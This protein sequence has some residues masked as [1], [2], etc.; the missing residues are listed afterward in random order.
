[1]GVLRAFVFEEAFD[2]EAIPVTTA[3]RALDL[4]LGPVL[5]RLALEAGWRYDPPVAERVRAADLTA[6]AVTADKYAVVREVLEAADGIGCRVVLLKGIATALR[7][8]PAPHL[9]GMDDIDV[10][11]EPSRQASLEAAIRARGFEQHSAAPAIAFA[12]LHHSMPFRRG[13]EGAWVELHGRLSPPGAAH[14]QDPQFSW[15]QVS[16]HLA[17]VTVSD[18]PALVMNHELQLVYTCARWAEE[19]APR[20]VFPLLDVALLLRAHGD[21]LDWNRVFLI[22]RGSWTGAAVRLVLSYLR[23][24][25]LAAIPARV[26]DELATL[27]RHLNDMS[28][29][30]LHRLTTRYVIDG[31]PFGQAL[32][33][34]G[35]LQMVWASVL[36]TRSP[37]ANLLSVPYHLAFPPGRPDRFHPRLAL[38]RLRRLLTR[39][40]HGRRDRQP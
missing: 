25:G 35:Q 33:T 3:A 36:G 31:R 13:A 38:E 1:L 24:I 29:D 10:L 14:A 16:Q 8:Y 9:R 12:S 20:A 4:G 7:Y 19:F 39:A 22:V 23:K 32:L 2:S 21:A 5:A 28:L 27:D 18:R 11:V 17:S 6:R 26:L 40:R 30:V 15:E 37:M 34:E